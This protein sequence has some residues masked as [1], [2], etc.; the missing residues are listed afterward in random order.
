VLEDALFEN[1]G[2]NGAKSRIIVV[3]RVRIWRSPLLAEGGDERTLPLHFKMAKVQ[4]K[5]DPQNPSVA[6]LE[7]Q[8]FKPDQDA[9][10]LPWFQL[11][12][13]MSGDAGPL[14]KRSI[15]PGP[16]PNVTKQTFARLR[17]Q[18]ESSLPWTD[19]FARAAETLERRQLRFKEEILDLGL[20]ALDTA[21]KIIPEDKTTCFLAFADEHGQLPG[22]RK[23]YASYLQ[24]MLPAYKYVTKDGRPVQAKPCALCST[25]DAAYPSALRGTGLNLTNLDRIG[26]FSGLEKDSA[27]KKFALCAACAD[28]LYIYSYHL[29]S[30][31]TARVAGAR[32]LLVPY[33]TSDVDKRLRFLRF[34][35]NYYVSKVQSGKPLVEEE[36]MLQHY[37]QEEAITSI[38]ILWADFGQ[39]LENVRGMVADVLPSRLRA[40]S[41]V[42]N[43]VRQARSA[44]F[45][46]LDYDDSLQPD[47]AFNYLGSLLKRP[48]GKRTEKAN[49]G[50][51]LFDL[52]RD[53]AA[54]AYHGRRVPEA[55]LWEEVREICE[56]YLLDAME[57]G[58]GLTNEGWNSKKG[59]AFLTMAG[60]ARHLCRFLYFLKKL[61]VYPPMNEWRYKPHNERLRESFGDLFE[62]TDGR[63]GIDTQEKA[64]AFLLGALFGK[65]MQVQGARGVNVGANALPWL[66][67][68]TLSGKDLPDLHRKIGDKLLT[69]MPRTSD[70]IRDVT[71]E[72]G[73]LGTL[74]GN[75]IKQDGTTTG[76]FLLL[77][78]SLS[79]SLMP[80]KAK[81]T[82]EQVDGEETA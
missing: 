9:A 73:Y 51:R 34:V 39:K 27:W 11:P 5:A 4:L 50:P 76:Y 6:V 62:D 59:V 3:G 29:Q 24:A 25:T 30:A 57:H 1:S 41:E 13:N 28:L 48:G 47:V 71:E 55:R 8:E 2:A 81:Q 78:Q 61:E 20:S 49:A 40:I 70:D 12:G 54:A 69:Y 64:Y 43:E 16:T 80:S 66:K 79:L 68:F 7:Q 17:S 44:P 23:D 42:A 58:Y 52:R 14:V 37:A 19:Y 18:A 53:I 45:P 21:I 35:E 72:L 67:R 31:F 38:T 74:L 10:R 46:E 15:S 32:A 77:G 75:D 82:N 33:T 22:D 56:A 36:R 26:V 65:L 63:T 60:W